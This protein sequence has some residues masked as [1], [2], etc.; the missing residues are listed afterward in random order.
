MSDKRTVYFNLESDCST[1]IC[2][3]TLLFESLDDSLMRVMESTEF[4]SDYQL[5]YGDQILVRSEGGRDYI[6]EIIT[7]SDYVHYLIV[8]GSVPN[9][10][11]TDFIHSLGGEWE[12][13]FGGVMFLHLPREKID[14]VFAGAGLD[15]SR[16]QEVFSGPTSLE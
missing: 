10:S 8:G 14:D 1:V 6:D 9:Q 11:F 7:P 16:Y 5:Y 3:E 15:L 12:T 2:H 4:L 13:E